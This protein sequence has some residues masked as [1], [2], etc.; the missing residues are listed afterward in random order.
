MEVRD[1]VVVVTG[2][3]NGIAAALARRF[4]AEGAAALSFCEWLAI[5]H[6]DRLG[7]SCLCPQGVRTRMLELDRGMGGLLW[8]GALTP[9]EVAGAVVN[10]LRDE[11]FLILPHP[12][13]L[14][15][16]GRKAS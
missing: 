15:Y 6:G 13:V 5:A 8:D 16:F 2:G 1:R 14:T 12:E 3:G 10:G 7:V 4:A 11:R 9:E